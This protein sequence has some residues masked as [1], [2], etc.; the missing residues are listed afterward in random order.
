M[1]NTNKAN[2]IIIAWVSI[3]FAAIVLL[4]SC[5]TT[6]VKCRDNMYSKTKIIRVSSYNKCRGLLN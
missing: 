4:S 2:A 6:K 3:V 5:S 1:T